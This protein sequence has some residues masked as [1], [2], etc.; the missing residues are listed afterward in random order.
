M[1][2]L[3]FK[4]TPNFFGFS[5]L[6]ISHEKKRKEKKIRASL[7]TQGLHIAI[8]CHPYPTQKPIPSGPALPLHNPNQVNGSLQGWDSCHGQFQGGM[9]LQS[10]DK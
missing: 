3:F 8:G 4:T 6:C 9:K 1:G 7:Y 5:A 10:C 2:V